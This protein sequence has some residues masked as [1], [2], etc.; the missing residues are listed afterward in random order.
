[1][2]ESLFAENYKNT[3]YWWDRT[4]RPT[5]K[6]IPLPKETEVLVIGSG[7]TGLCTAIQTCRNGLDT[8]VLDAQDAG[9]GGSSR[10]GGQVSPSI[11]PSFQDLSRKYGEEPARELLKEGYNALKWIG[12]FIQEENIDCDFKRV[13]RYYGAHSLS[14]FKHLEKIINE[15]PEGLQL[16]VNLIP[17]SQ[18]H[19]EIGSDFYHGGIVHQNHASLDPARFHQ[20]LLE[21]ALTS[22][23]QIKTHCAVNKIEK[24]GGIFQIHTEAGTMSAREVVVATSGYTGTVTPWHRRRVIPI[25]SYIISTELLAEDLVNELIPRDRVITDSRKLVVYY[26]ASPDRKRILFGGRVSLNETDPDKCAKPL[27]KKLTQIFPQLAKIK[28]SH[29]WMG[30]VGFTFDHMPHTGD[31]EGV[32]YAMG[33]CGS[34][35]CLSSYFG[36]KLGQRLAGLP[37]GNTIFTDINFQTRPF[38]KGNPWFLAPSILYFQLRDRFLS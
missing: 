15:Q 18:Q 22:G 33:Y 23:A 38:Y 36:T 12:D 20:G 29:S 19:T 11:K 5:I 32:H 34:G 16:D 2:T 14:Q 1:M 4:P 6:E 13:G 3:P 17:K 26:R 37:Q 30:F 7:Y 10:N 35:I 28:V 9:W 8:V 27:H 25:G 21:G 24:K 31:K